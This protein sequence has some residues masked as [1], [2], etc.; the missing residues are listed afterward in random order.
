MKYRI[1]FRNGMVVTIEAHSITAI[2]HTNIKFR[3]D[4]DQNKW[5]AWRYV[6]P[7]QV[8]FVAPVEDCEVERGA[9]P[10]IAEK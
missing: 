9:V 8:L 4:D 6:N 1:G 7:G 5:D 3:K 10:L 2:D